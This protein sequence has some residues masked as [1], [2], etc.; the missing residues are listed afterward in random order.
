MIAYCVMPDHVHLLLQARA[1]DA[2]LRAAIHDFKRRTGFAWK[3]R[4]GQCLW[5]EGFHDYVLRDEDS[6]AGLVRYVVNNPIRARLVEDVTKY[7]YVGSSRYQIEELVDV[8]VDWRP[9]WKMCR[10]RGGF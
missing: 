4:K 2:D 5:Q 8:A 10:R 1:D 7:P 6:L 3:R 9:P